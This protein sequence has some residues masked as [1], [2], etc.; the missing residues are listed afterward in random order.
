MNVIER[1]TLS[2]LSHTQ[3]Q[4]LTATA[5][6]LKPNNPPHMHIVMA[7]ADKAVNWLPTRVTGTVEI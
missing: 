6:N 2:L 1:V 5:Y 4:R 3:T 7:K